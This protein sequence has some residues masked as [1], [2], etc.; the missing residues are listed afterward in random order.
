MTFLSSPIDI[1]YRS[2]AMLFGNDNLVLYLLVN[3]V[4]VE[5]AYKHQQSMYV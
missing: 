3:Y 5:V 4:G 1:I 2:D